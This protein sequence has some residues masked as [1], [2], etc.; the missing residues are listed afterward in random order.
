MSHHF[1]KENGCYCLFITVIIDYRA[2]IWSSWSS[3]EEI[4]EN[5][6]PKNWQYSSHVIDSS[7]EM[8]DFATFERSSTFCSFS[9]SAMA[10]ASWCRVRKK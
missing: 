5:E 3:M 9:I 1:N 8:S 6:E 10:I 4:E 2:V 7:H